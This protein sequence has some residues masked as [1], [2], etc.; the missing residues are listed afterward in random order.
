VDLVRILAGTGALVVV[1]AVL[2]ACGSSDQRAEQ[3]PAEAAGAAEATQATFRRAAVVRGLD[4]PVALAATGGQPRR[5]YVVEQRG[6]VRVVQNGRLL[7]GFFL[8]I[9]GRVQS[10]GERGLLGLAFDPLYAQNRFVYVNFTDRD[11]HT[12]IVRFRTNAT[13]ALPATA[14]VLLRVEQPFGNHNGGHL[15]FGPDGRLWIGLGDG[16]SGG[17]PRGYAQNMGSLLGK[18]LRLDVR[19]PGSAPEIAGLGLRNPWRYSF[20]RA[21]GDLYIADVGQSAV[22]EVHFTPRARLTQLQNYGWNLYEGSRRFSSGEPGA[23]RLVFPVFEYGRE[24][25]NCSV[26]GGHVYRGSARPA[27]RGRYIVGDYCSGIV[28]SFRVAS[29]AARD[30]RTEPFR[31]PGLTSF[32][33]SPAGELFAVSH[34]GVLYR[35]T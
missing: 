27:L 5:L 21:T 14:R 3:P 24:Q 15:V 18:M 13:R 23:G 9:R 30:V 29:G 6:T 2:A 26:T 34:G 31:V 1:A 25:G 10:G 16:G 35:L 8:D 32:G 17:D 28:W 12:R 19:R 4:D 22:E 7:P 20:D 33:E 11:G